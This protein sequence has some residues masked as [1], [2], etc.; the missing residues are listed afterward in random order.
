MGARLSLRADA[1]PGSTDVNGVVFKKRFT[2]ALQTMYSNA[3]AHP[4]RPRTARS[5]T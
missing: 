5:L 3:L 2:N 4:V 1:G